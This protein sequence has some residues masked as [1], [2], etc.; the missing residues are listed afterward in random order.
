MIL[1]GIGIDSGNFSGIPVIPW[2]VP[3]D[4]IVAN[5]GLGWDPRS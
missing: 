1:V 3:Q 2:V 4:A 5:E